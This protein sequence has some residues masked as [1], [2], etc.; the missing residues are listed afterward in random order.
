SRHD[1]APGHHSTS[2]DDS[3]SDHANQPRGGAVPADEPESL[4]VRPVLAEPVR[5]SPRPGARP[6][7][8]EPR[9]RRSAVQLLEFPELPHAGHGWL[10]RRLRLAS[11][12]DGGLPPRAEEWARL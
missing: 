6:L 7:R 8:L 9:L 4:P 10:R 11:A 5:L 2:R 12:E 3:A 1:A